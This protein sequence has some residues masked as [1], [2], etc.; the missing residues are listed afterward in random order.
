MVPNSYAGGVIALASQHGKERVMAKPLWHGLG[1]TLRR[2]EHVDTDAFGSF[3][4]EQPRP[5]DAL[6]TCRLKAEAGMDALGLDLGIASEGAFGPHPA[7]PLLPVGR[8]W[9]TFVERPRNLVI[10]EQLVSRFTNFS[11]C[12]G[13]DPEAIAA[14]LRGVGFPSHGLMVQPHRGDRSPSAGW[15]AKGV[16]DGQRLAELMAEAV[17]RSPLGL[18]WVETDMRAHCNPTRMASIRRLS[19]QLVRRVASRCPS[20]SVPGWGLVDTRAGLP[21]RWC[22]LATELVRLELFGCA[23]CGL[24]SE[25]PRRDGLTSADPGHCPYCNP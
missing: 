15:L 10:T 18:A 20:C 4:G 12:I 22:G 13:T 21:C 5:S 7:L 2:A 25:L 14:W 19:F 6:T 24:T 16:H 11:S 9:I 3:S 8:E 23:A 17:Q 1:L